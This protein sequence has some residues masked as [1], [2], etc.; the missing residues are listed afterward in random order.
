MLTADL[1]DLMQREA[2]TLRGDGKGAA[3]ALV[4]D[5]AERLK[6]LAARLERMGESAEATPVLAFAE[7]DPDGVRL[8]IAE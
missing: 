3:A 2:R 1:I 8:A 7:P 6:T 5:G 4:E